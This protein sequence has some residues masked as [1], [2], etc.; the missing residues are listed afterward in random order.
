MKS[1]SLNIYFIAA[2]LLAGLWLPQPPAVSARCVQE[3]A[4][5]NLATELSTR[6]T[7]VGQAISLRIG[8]VN[9]KQY[10]PP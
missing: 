4:A 2:T 1:K 5:K 10:E 8:I 9:A 3:E 6:E 7:Y